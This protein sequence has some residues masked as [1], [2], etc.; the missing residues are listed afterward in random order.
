MSQKPLQLH[1]MGSE[2]GT[3]TYYGVLQ[4][5]HN[6]DISNINSRL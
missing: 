5:R 4:N 3:L 2:S 1:C 6:K